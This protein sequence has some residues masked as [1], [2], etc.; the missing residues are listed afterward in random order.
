MF[1]IFITADFAFK[2]WEG[3]RVIVATTLIIT[4][5]SIMQVFTADHCLTQQLLLT[6]ISSRIS[7]LLGAKI[8]GASASAD[9]TADAP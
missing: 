1:L 5:V 8:E 4:A 3:E 2:Y 7:R 9:P 6:P